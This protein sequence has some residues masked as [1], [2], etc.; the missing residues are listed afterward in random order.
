MCSGTATLE[1]LLAEVPTTI[2]YKT[3]WLNY[4]I[5]KS[6]MKAKYAGIP[7]IIAG[8]E[9]FTELIQHQATKAAI[10]EDLE[11]NLTNLEMKIEVMQE[12][13]RKIVRTDFSEFS[14]RIYEDHRSR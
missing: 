11:N 8:K 4:L 6:M 3:S 14:D 7:N 5:Y 2:I 10:A 1:G 12:V 13:K 9:I